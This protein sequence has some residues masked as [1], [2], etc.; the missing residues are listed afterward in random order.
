MN[1]TV[2]K[3][4]FGIRNLTFILTRVVSLT[5]P[6][7][8]N[9]IY[10]VSI[11]AGPAL[12]K[13]NLETQKVEETFKLEGTDDSYKF[14]TCEV[15]YNE[16]LLVVF[17]C[18]QSYVG[19]CP[20]IAIFDFKTRKWFGGKDNVGECGEWWPFRRV[21]AL[22]DHA[23]ENKGCFL[24]DQREYS[25]KRYKNCIMK[26][27]VCIARDALFKTGKEVNAYKNVVIQCHK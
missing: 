24:F 1:C 3:T 26:F 13:F 9:Y 2:S 22:K 6:F 20:K 18:N 12:L 5:D 16:I 19:P 4:M 27:S 25:E 17:V 14:I 23:S 7:D 10:I 8:Y 15:F 11:S 21:W